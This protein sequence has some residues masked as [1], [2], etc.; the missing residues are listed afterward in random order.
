M[1]VVIDFAT[2]NAAF[3]NGDG[4]IQRIL[5]NV[6]D[7]INHG[8]QAGNIRDINGNTVGEWRLTHREVMAWRQ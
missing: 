3:D 6:V 5:A 1:R 8:E 2:D 4:E 7:D